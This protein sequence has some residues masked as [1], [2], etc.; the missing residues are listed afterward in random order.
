MLIKR[1]QLLGSMGG[2][3]MLPMFM[4]SL[5]AEEASTNDTILVVI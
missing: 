2:M 4:N 3:A 1:R 5:R